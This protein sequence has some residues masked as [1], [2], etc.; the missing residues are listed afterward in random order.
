MKNF[1]KYLK[2]HAIKTINY[3]KKEK[4]P[5]RTEESQSYHKQNFC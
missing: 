4:L 2:E 1:C 5:L 3:E